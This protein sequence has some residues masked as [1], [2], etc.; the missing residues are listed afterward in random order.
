MNTH[1][2]GSDDERKP[3]RAGR[4]P[5]WDD[6][7]VWV[8][9]QVEDDDTEESGAASLAIHLRECLPC[10]SFLRPTLD[11]WIAEMERELFALQQV[12]EQYRRARSFRR[13]HLPPLRPRD[14]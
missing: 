12:K 7:V 5:Y 10:R 13:H 8:K 14:E 2:V 6:I 4:C 3:F 9:R 11:K 1:A